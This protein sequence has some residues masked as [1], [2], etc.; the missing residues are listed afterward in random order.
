[1]DWHIWDVS[2]LYKLT[3]DILV[4]CT[5]DIEDLADMS[6]VTRYI[7]LHN[8]CYSLVVCPSSAMCHHLGFEA[9]RSLST[10]WPVVVYIHHQGP[11]HVSWTPILIILEE[12]H[13]LHQSL[14]SLITPLV[15]AVTKPLRSM[16]NTF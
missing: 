6:S 2:C 16:E 5:V 9:V 11:L 15:K 13:N 7:W 10:A 4:I 1:M 12:S 14:L 3:N 8:V